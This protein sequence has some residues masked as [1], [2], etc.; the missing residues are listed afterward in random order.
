MKLR[1]NRAAKIIAAI[2]FAVMLVLAA[3]SAIGILLLSEC[4]AYTDGGIRMREDAAEAV[5]H[6]KNELYFEFAERMIAGNLTDSQRASYERQLAEEHTNLSVIIRNTAKDETLYRNFEAA[7]YEYRFHSTGRRWVSHDAVDG[8]TSIY[9]VTT[10]IDG[11]VYTGSGEIAEIEIEAFLK[12]ELS[13]RDAFFRVLQLVDALIAMRHALFW[14]VGVTLALA[15]ACFLFLMSAAGHDAFVEGIRLRML[16]RVPLDVLLAAYFFAGAFVIALGDVILYGHPVIVILYVIFAAGAL[17]ALAVT[18]LLTFAVRIK[19]GQLLRN[20]LIY[21][22]LRFLWQGILLIGHAIAQL[23]LWWIAGIA[24]VCVSLL[25]L[26][27]LAGSYELSIVGWFISRPI[28]LAALVYLVLMLRRLEK[29][30]QELAAGNTDRRVDTKWM[31]P[32]LARHGEALGS[33]REGLAHA[34]EARMRSERMKSELI[35][36]VSHDIK[37]PLTSI[38][39]Y[40]DLLKTAGLDSPEAK[41]YLEVLEHQS[42]RL[43]KLTEDL[44]EASKASAG[45]LAVNPEPT[46]VNV[47]LA[48]A[49]GE[50]EEML[51]AAGITPTLRLQGDS[52]MIVTDGRLL[53]RVFDNLLSNIRKYA[54]PGTRAYITSEAADGNIIVTFRN[55]SA[56]ELRTDGEELTERFVRGDASRHTE[57]SGLGLSIARSLTELLGGSFTVT[58]DGDLFKVTIRFPEKNA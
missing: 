15:M 44:I 43:R 32:V 58:V 41:Q 49:L 6:L 45:T 55:I 39:N 28:Y 5:Y 27:F 20:T 54:M 8:T 37:T 10:A 2:L 9:A 16:D 26:L 53:W 52:L 11:D 19:A 46:D 51:T 40:V 1:E 3:A 4:G 14:I 56:E 21:R 17:T 34:V 30:G 31:L 38:I 7:D 50:Y 33:M 12:T 48:Q 25:E 57:G 22:I 35:T 24:F 47:L 42:A 18:L 29:A 13:A 23:P 36:N